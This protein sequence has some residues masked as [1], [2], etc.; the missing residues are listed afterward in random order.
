M[1][2]HISSQT[3]EARGN[4]YI[5]WTADHMYILMSFDRCIDLCTC[6]SNQDRAH[7]Y[8]PKKVLSFT[9]SPTVSQRAEFFLLLSAWNLWQATAFFDQHVLKI[10]PCY[11]SCGSFLLLPGIQPHECT[12]ILSILDWICLYF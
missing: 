3:Y 11:C 10:H 2:W 4:F 12:T 5:Q 8:N 6:H 1:P 7:V 9:P